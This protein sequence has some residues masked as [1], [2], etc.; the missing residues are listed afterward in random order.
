MSDTDRLA[1]LEIMLAHQAN[2]IDEL[3]TELARAFT[4]LDR[5]QKTLK[6]LAERFLALEET[7]TPRAEVTRPPHY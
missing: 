6:E 4:Q 1:E 3:S 7:A 2:T 5:Q